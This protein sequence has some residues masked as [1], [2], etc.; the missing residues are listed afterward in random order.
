MRSSGSVVRLPKP[1][2]GIAI[3]RDVRPYGFDEEQASKSDAQEREER[4]TL[5][6]VGPSIDVLIAAA[7]EEGRQEGLREGHARG[8]EEG[9][10]T[11]RKAATLLDKALRRV[12]DERQTLLAKAERDIVDLAL[13]IASRVLRRE[14]DVD[15]DLVTRVVPDALRRA[16]PLEEV[17]VRVHPSDYAHIKSVPGLEA[18]L[19]EIRHLVLVEDRRVSVGGCLVETGSGAI[20][21]R[22]ETQLEEITRALARAAGGQAIGPDK[23]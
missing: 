13:A 6:E 10:E 12:G 7:R 21:A 14:V 23:S 4:T 11:A 5:A 15:R 1:A 9:L 2:K 16:S 8:R 18:S 22:V 17:V 3:V 20:D 19:G